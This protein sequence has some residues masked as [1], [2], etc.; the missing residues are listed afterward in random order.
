[1]AGY[2]LIEE[3]MLKPINPNGLDPNPNRMGFLDYLKELRDEHFPFSMGHG[4]RLV[5]LED[6]LVAAID[7]L[8]A[9]CAEIRRTLNARA[10]ELWQIGGHVQVVFRYRLHQADDFYFDVGDRRVSLRSIFGAVRHEYQEGVDY[11]LTGYNLT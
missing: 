9:V 2:L 1:M 10:N 6:V 11:Y 8:P 5:G 7:N 4:L 3:R